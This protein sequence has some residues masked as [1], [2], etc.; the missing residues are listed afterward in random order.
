MN[1]AKT[2]A[3]VK[4]ASASI[5]FYQKINLFNH[6]PTQSPANCLVR[7][8]AMTRF[9]LNAKN[10]KE[11]F[12]W[13]HVADFALHMKSDNKVIVTWWSPRWQ[14][15]CSAGCA[16]I[17]TRRAFDGQTSASSRMGADSR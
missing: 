15:S 13:D 16:F 7:S 5:A 1:G 14:S 12:E 9:G 10:C 17:T 11:P 2:S 4:A 3:P 8:A 6:E